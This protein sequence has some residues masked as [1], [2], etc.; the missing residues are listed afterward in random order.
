MRHLPELPSLP[1]AALK[2]ACVGTA[3]VFELV[4]GPEESKAACSSCGAIRTSLYDLPSEQLLVPDVSFADF[5]HVL[6]KARKS[7]ALEE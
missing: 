5:S 3:P 7:V 4:V 6:D 1:A 2:L